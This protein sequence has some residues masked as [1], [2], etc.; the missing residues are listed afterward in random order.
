M[1][2]DSED[3]TLVG[4]FIYN[5]EDIIG[6][7]SNESK[8]KGFDSDL[9]ALSLCASYA[10]EEVKTY[11]LYFPNPDLRSNDTIDTRI[12]GIGDYITYNLIDSTAWVSTSDKVTPILQK[13]AFWSQG[14]PFNNLYPT[15]HEWFGS[16]VKIVD[17]G[18]FPLAIAKIMT[19]FENT[20]TF[21]FNN[22]TVNWTSLKSN[23]IP[24]SSQA[25]N[26]AAYLLYGISKGCKSWCFFDGTFT[27]PKRAISYMKLAG[28]PNARKWRYTWDRLLDM[29]KN[30]KPVIAYAIPNINITGSHAWN[31]DGY[32]VITRNAIFEKL[33]G[34]AWQCNVTQKQT[35]NMVHCDFGWG[36]SWN[37]YYVSGVFDTRDPNKELDYSEGTE[38]H[39]FNNYIHIIS[40]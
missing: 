28:Y 5:I 7:R 35:R 23:Y 31:I 21:T 2:N 22:Y 24:S 3:D 4:N 32:K 10:A 20:K 30:G 16:E 36:S 37:G 26:S 9:F 18:C 6:S 27:F 33:K 39:N 19:H 13:Y 40:Y 17:A 12:E 14:E 25:I 15:R 29:L 8:T 11:G 1:Y 38:D 34:G